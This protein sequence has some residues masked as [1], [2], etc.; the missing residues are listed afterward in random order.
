MKYINNDPNKGIEYDWKL[1]I[2]DV[3]YCDTDSIYMVN[4][5]KH[6]HIID[7]YNKSICATFKLTW[8]DIYKS[9]LEELA[10]R[11]KEVERYEIHKQ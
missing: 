11:R 7:E 2:K 9:L 4:C 8:K 1:I 10:E 6:R 5:N 3:V